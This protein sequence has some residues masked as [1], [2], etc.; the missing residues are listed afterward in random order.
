MARTEFQKH[1]MAVEIDSFIQAMETELNEL[2]GGKPSIIRKVDDS[3][4]I[5]GVDSRG[6]P[7]LEVFWI[8]EAFWCVR[9]AK[10]EADNCDTLSEAFAIAKVEFKA[11]YEDMQDDG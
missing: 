11:F 8:E 6:N 2:T 5:A 10:K 4:V 3:I 9:C 7:T 1:K